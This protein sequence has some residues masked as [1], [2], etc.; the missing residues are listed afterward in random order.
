M[1]FNRHVQVSLCLSLGIFVALQR[2]ASDL[3]VKASEEYVWLYKLVFYAAVSLYWALSLSIA[4]C[5]SFEDPVRYMEFLDWI[6]E[7]LDW[8]NKSGKMLSGKPKVAVIGG[9]VCGLTMSWALKENGIEFDCFERNNSIGG[10]WYNGVYDVYVFV[11]FFFFFFAQI[12]IDVRKS[13][14]YIY[15]MNIIRISSRATEFKNYPMPKSFGD[16]PSQEN[17]IQYLRGFARDK[18]VFN[19]VKTRL[20]LRH[21]VASVDLIK[22]SKQGVYRVFVKNLETQKTTEHFY[23]AVIY[24]NGH[25]WDKKY[26]GNQEHSVDAIKLPG[27]EKFTGKMIHS[28]DYK[29]SSQLKDQRVLVVGIGNSGCDIAVEASRFGKESH[30]S[31]RRGRWIMPRS[32]AGIPLTELLWG[33]APYWVQ[34]LLLRTVIWFTFGDYRKYGIPNPDHPPF[35][36]HP[37]VNSD[38]LLKL[39][40]KR[41]IPHSGLKAF[42][43]E[44]RVEFT[45]GTSAE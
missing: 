42:T 35:V 39:A 25:H 20:H 37:T 30:L 11:F 3:R 31:A 12:W 36:T 38:L 22:D 19:S 9:G 45:D 1:G 29:H 43:G 41:I 15:R 14:D 8:S 17:M 21:E 40:L 7:P 27:I 18:Q 32:F 10:N 5:L 2:Y 13:V 44:N 24:A 33:S 28:K 6:K 16:F 4:Y 34:R 23:D 26:P